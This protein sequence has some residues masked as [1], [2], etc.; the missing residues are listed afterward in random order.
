MFFHIPKLTDAPKELLE[1]IQKQDIRVIMGADQTHN[2]QPK[3]NLVE[4]QRFKDYLSTLRHGRPGDRDQLT[5]EAACVGRDYGLTVHTIFECMLGWDQGSDYPWQPADL[6]AKIQHA[7]RYAQS[8]EGA[9]QI[10][11]SQFDEKEPENEG[12]PKASAISSWD[13]RNDGSIKPTSANFQVFYGMHQFNGI[14]G[15]EYP[16]HK[17]FAF[18]T[19]DKQY[20][21]TRMPFWRHADNNINMQLEESDYNLLRGYL[22][23]FYKAEFT[24]VQIQKEIERI[25]CLYP[26][27]PLCDW[28]DAL[29]W[30]GKP[31]LRKLFVEYMNNELLECPEEVAPKAY[32]EYMRTMGVCFCLSA[33]MRAYEPGCKWDC[34][35]V[36]AGPPAVGKSLFVQIMG[37]TWSRV[38][39][40]MNSD[41]D[42]L[43]SMGGAWLI[44]YPEISAYKKEDI[45]KVK[46][47]IDSREDVYRPPYSTTAVV[48][49]RSCILVWT[50]NPLQN[51]PQFLRDTTGNRKF[52]VIDVG[53]NQFQFEALKRDREQLWA[54]A[55]YMY[56][57]G[58]RPN[59]IA[60]PVADV[61]RLVQAE[62]TN[63][64][65]DVSGVAEDIREWMGSGEYKKLLETYTANIPG[66]RVKRIVEEVLQLYTLRD[67][68]AV[69]YRQITT[70]MAKLGWRKR[71]NSDGIW[72][73]R[74]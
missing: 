27:D 33:V 68:S 5:Y 47:F 53:Q 57:Q 8:S 18:N 11:L 31:R 56:R 70:E 36:F 3:D 61:A 62:N 2:N 55:V 13:V 66:I 29:E 20:V 43:M 14:E 26:F 38:L 73:I 10:D 51:D 41:R 63:T 52:L 71:R 46:A 74:K 19:R 16:L 34:M 15:V 50:L 69:L 58:Q 22:S 17:L 54:E 44:E 67:K 23:K 39:Y 35:F 65:Y 37:G 40:T 42:G 72:F 64:D 21:L 9:K 6:R 12:E 1:I 48:R 4:K 30:D 7:F 45:N 24:I 49:P 28:L 25:A 60:D 59:L 32:E